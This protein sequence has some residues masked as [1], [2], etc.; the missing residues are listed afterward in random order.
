MS[1]PPRTRS[2]F[3]STQKTPSPFA[4]TAALVVAVTTYQLATTMVAP[5]LPV[6]TKDLSLSPATTGL[7]QALFFLVAALIEVVVPISDRYGRR[8]MLV[9]CL[10]LTALGHVLAATAA[11]EQMF[12]AGRVMQGLSGVAFPLAFVTLHK[13]L[14]PIQFGRSVGIIAAV[15]LG[16][17][18]VDT[19][20]GSY[21]AESLGFRSIFWCM[22]A[23]SVTALVLV[24][25][26]VPKDDAKSTMSIDW[27]GI[28][29]LCL[30]IG[31]L[32]FGLSQ[33]GTLGWTS[34]TVL[35]TGIGGIVAIGLF[36]LVEYRSR[37]PLVQTALLR[38]R[39]VWPLLVVVLLSMGGMFTTYSY[40]LPL[41]AQDHSSGY[42][43][44]PV[45]ATLRFIVPAAAAAF[46]C[47]PI[48][49]RLAPRLGWRRITV[50]TLAVSAA[51]MVV[52]AFFPQNQM[53]VAILVPV[54]GFCYFG[55][56]ETAMNG[57]GVLLSPKN[58]PSFL[59]G[60]AGCCFA[61]GVS[62]G[63]AAATAA[64]SHN[65]TP[66]D[67]IGN[68]YLLALAAMAAMAV[69]A[70]AVSFLIPRPAA[71]GVAATADHQ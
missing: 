31:A 43:L 59:P 35:I 55:A 66:T 4:L 47:A 15:N 52:I 46:I 54:I 45:T 32:L 29:V 67:G 17:T 8:A 23:I 48:A 58:S 9:V 28:V 39:D 3:A 53:L 56:T 71:S 36:P 22:A 25:R 41:I 14:S 51:C 18:G 42:G 2:V 20:A 13:N 49:G 6:I 65:S 38:S 44:S 63:T 27:A 70:A 64:L 30:G 60:I 24:H 5:T 69:A 7:T 61:L 34:P 40:L 19:L 33:G 11:S 68:G 1:A 62:V 50:S 12:L 57:L 10:A 16:I 21:L 26:I 37:L